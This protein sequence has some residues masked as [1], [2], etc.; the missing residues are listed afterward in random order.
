MTDFYLE[1]ADRSVSVQ[2]ERKG[3]FVDLSW[4]GDNITGNRSVK[5]PS[6]KA[7]PPPTKVQPPSKKKKSVHEKQ[8]S[9]QVPVDFAAMR[10]S[11][12][13]VALEGRSLSLQGNKGDMVAR[14][15]AY[16]RSH[17]SSSESSASGSKSSEKGVGRPKR[18]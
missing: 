18:P 5:H 2:A 8:P 14:L 7:Q 13:R 4:H 1:D 17:G 16:D 6:K 3:K 10:I 12:L 9:V 11:E 15:H